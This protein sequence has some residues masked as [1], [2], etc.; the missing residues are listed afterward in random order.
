M[1]WAVPAASAL[2]MASVG[3]FTAAAAAPPVA[4][5]ASVASPAAGFSALG[6]RALLLI[7]ERSGATV[8]AKNANAEL[9]IAST[10]KLM[11]AYVTLQREPLD[12]RLTEQPYAAGLGES[13]APV[14]VG[15]QLSVAD[16]LR[17]ML[18][19]S[20]NNVAYSLSVDVGG[21]ESNFVAMMNAAA[22]KLNLG[23]T[24]Y[25]TPIGLD[26]PGDNYSTAGD[27]ARLARVLMRNPLFREVVDE[28]SARLADGVVVANRNTLVGTYPWVVGVKTGN[29]TDAGECLVGAAKLN[30]VRLISV[31][32]GAPSA[33]ASAADTLALL[34]YGLSLY[35]S[36]PIATAGHAYATVPVQGRSRPVRLIARRSLSLVIARTV[37]IHAALD[38][39]PDRLVGPLAAGTV[40][41]SIEVSENGR[42]VQSVALVT[43]SA[44][45]APPPPA[46]S[47]P[48]A[49]PIAWLAGGGGL[50][51]ILLGCSLL[52]MRRRATR[53]ALGMQ[54]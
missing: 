45:P 23:R 48:P 12:A 30:G 15:A 16:M 35:R 20:G 27:L 4:A 26:T 8:F 10:T 24:H 13:L 17:A 1:R 42:L 9:A 22:A 28:P 18:L 33:A 37:A 36:V 14:P 25:T 40:E 29:T 2:W 49:E 39:V 6:A 47:A 53:C 52:R 34:R 21:S 51:A 3:T 50:T 32:L 41:G 5:P 31:V 54:R 44:V 43:A 19:P 38:D 46:L 7:A 11:T